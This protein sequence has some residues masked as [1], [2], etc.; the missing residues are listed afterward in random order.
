MVPPVVLG[1]NSA[2]SDLHHLSLSGVHLG[3]R[4][5]RYL[6]S[7]SPGPC[8]WRRLDTQGGMGKAMLFSSC[9][10]WS[11]SLGFS[12]LSVPID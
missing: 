10:A 7:T 11:K 9:V 8:G 5:L 6:E 3:Y 1:A 12:G 4:K 2:P